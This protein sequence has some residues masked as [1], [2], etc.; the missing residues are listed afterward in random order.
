MANYWER[1]EKNI[2]RR[3]GSPYFWL[4]YSA[5]GKRIKESTKTNLITKARKMLKQR[6]GMAVSGIHP[7]S[8]RVS[9]NAM[10]DLIIKDYEINGRKSIDRLKLSI[11]HLE[12]HFGGMRADKIRRIHIDDYI[13]N[14]LKDGAMNAT[15]NAELACIRRMGNLALEKELIRFFPKLKLLKLVD[16]EGKPN[17]RTG[18]FEHAQFLDLRN[19][20]PD[21]LKP[22]VTLGYESGMR[23][24]EIRNLKW[25]QVELATGKIG[26]EQGTTKN[27]E[28]RVFY[29]SD[30]LKQM[31][32]ALLEERK[33]D[34]IDFEYLFKSNVGGGKIINL[35][36]AW[37]NA[38]RKTG[39]G[40]GYRLN[41]KYVEKWQGEYPPGPIFHDFRRTAVRNMVRAGVP[42]SVAMKI[43]GHKDR[44][45]F[46]R[47]NI[48]DEKDIQKASRQM[49]AYYESYESEITTEVINK[50]FQPDAKLTHSDQQDKEG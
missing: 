2:Y 5:N 21:F 42:E 34:G 49:R 28:G 10:K 23:L 39:L 24:D 16:K 41:R 32:G 4:Q 25:S 50:M 20:L 37:N 30:D 6:E 11:R 7:V 47:Y 29:M 1:I 3:K 19:N 17:T 40:Y 35:R 13:D 14:R 18:Y 44:S 38:C 33:A 22:L 46:E 43:S 36:R 15:I 27:D 9:F 26:L 12:K 31:L 45:V 48:T 8:R